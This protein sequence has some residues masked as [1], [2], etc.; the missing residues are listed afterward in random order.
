MSVAVGEG[1]GGAGHEGEVG[2]RGLRVKLIFSGLSL[3]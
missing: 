1:K 3:G 2:A